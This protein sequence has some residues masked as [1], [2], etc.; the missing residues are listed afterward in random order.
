[1]YSLTSFPTQW[2]TWKSR[3]VQ[4]R[5]KVTRQ[6]QSLVKNMGTFPEKMHHASHESDKY[7]K[8]TCFHYLFLP[9]TEDIAVGNGNW[10]CRSIK[11]E[12]LVLRVGVWLCA[13]L[14]RE[15]FLEPYGWI[16]KGNGLEQTEGSLQL[17][18]KSWCII[19]LKKLPILDAH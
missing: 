15:V 10:H 16:K 13:W 8:K 14:C 19:Y 18:I 12:L 6:Q 7:F 2:P 1:M 17:M 9:I 4:S 5:K 11:P 3:M